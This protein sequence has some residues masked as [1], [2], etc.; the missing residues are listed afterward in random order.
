LEH[1]KR[2]KRR[3]HTKNPLG[4]DQGEKRKKEGDRGPFARGTGGGG[5]GGEKGGKT[6]EG[7][8]FVTQGKRGKREN[9]PGGCES[10]EPFFGGKEEREKEGEEL[11]YQNQRPRSRCRRGGG[12]GELMCPPRKTSFERR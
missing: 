5:G 11:T 6:G 2:R 10:G 12:R 4:F 8:F 1:H 9:L 3:K 7:V